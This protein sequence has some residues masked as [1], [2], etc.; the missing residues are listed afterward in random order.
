MGQHPGEFLACLSAVLCLGILLGAAWQGGAEYA[1]Y[2]WLVFWGCLCLAGAAVY[3]RHSLSWLIVAVCVLL[4]GMGRYYAAAL[5]AGDDISRLEGQRVKV[6][7]RL[8]AAPVAVPDNKGG[9][10]VHYEV[11]CEELREKGGSRKA[12]GCLLVYANAASPGRELAAKLPVRHQEGQEIIDWEKAPPELWGQTGDRL[13]VSGTVRRVRDYGNPGRINR[14]MSLAARGIRGQLLADKGSLTVAERDRDAQAA[15]AVLAARVRGFYRESME[16]VMPRQD[17]AAIFAMLFGGYQGIK[18]ELLEAFTATGIVHILSVSGSHIT[19]LAATAGIVGRLLHLSAGGAAGLAVLTIL[20]YALL[21]GAI[22]PVIRSTLM[23]ILTLLALTLDRAKDARH[24]LSMVALG[25]L[26]YSPLLLYD[27]SFQLSFGATAGLLYISP[28]LRTALRKKFVLGKRLV[29]GEGL[30][31]GKR[32]SLFAA[33]SLAVTMGAQLA[34]LPV[35]A[36]YFN[37]LSLSSLL[38]NLL[39]TPVV[40]WIIVIG[41]LAGLAGSLLP[42]VGKGVFMA[43]SLALGLVYEMSR[44]VAALPA[45]QVY[46]PSMGVISCGA[47]YLGLWWLLLP[48]AARRA[49]LDKIQHSPIKRSPLLGSCIGRFCHSRYWPGGRRGTAVL[50]ALLLLAVFT[51]CRSCFRTEALQVHFIDVGQGDAALV[52]TPHGRAFMVDAGGVRESGYD[53]GRMVDVPY[54]LHYGIRK[55]DYIFLTHAHDDHA[56]GVRGILGKIPVGAIMVGHEGT[57]EYLKAFGRGSAARE[58]KLLAPLKENTC[59]E[60]DGVRIEVLFSPEEREIMQC[61]SQAT[62]NE[63]SNLI[64]VSYGAASFLFT[65]DLTAAQEK[66]LVQRGTLLESTVLKVGHHGSRTSSSEEFL[67]AV[68]PRWAVVSCGYGNSFGHPHKEALRRIESATAAR[69]LRTDKQ[70]AIVFRTDG[71]QMEVESY[72]DK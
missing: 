62:G 63:Y 28:V 37:T 25:L 33:D 11:A 46:L 31:V 61:S 59:M 15:I 71:R 60:L 50:L 44:R 5:P 57:E 52:I 66:L 4:L 16:E 1:A 40:E 13:T 29:P 35:I 17:A 2:I 8:T 10:R 55:L 43:A 14:E 39:I 70:G 3:R 32:L 49:A 69:L 6:A 19:L 9:M 67:Q 51:G 47:Y 38:A 24:L 26:L 27:I 72:R 64:R 12:G 20:F 34:V 53:I 65:G 36:W 7:G 58:E 56:A 42:L 54:L 41:L 48:G 22:P 68:N 23:G 30:P 45:S 18:P 21:A